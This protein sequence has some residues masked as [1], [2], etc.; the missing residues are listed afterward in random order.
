MRLRSER[1][2]PSQDDGVTTRS[3]V[4]ANNVDLQELRVPA[5]AFVMASAGKLV[6]IAVA[7]L[8]AGI[9]CTLP[10]MSNVIHHHYMSVSLPARAARLSTMVHDVIGAFSVR[11]ALDLGL[12][13]LLAQRGQMMD[14]EIAASLE[15][16]LEGMRTLLEAM[17]SLD[18]LS[19]DA[20][21]LYSMTALSAKHLV[22]GQEPY[23]GSLI[24]MN[25]DPSHVNAFLTIA[26]SVRL[27]RAVKKVPKHD[28]KGAEQVWT[29]FATHTADLSRPPAR[30]MAKM[31]H[32]DAEAAEKR[33][34]PL[35]V[36][37][38]ACG[39]G[40]YGQ[41][42]LRAYPHARVTFL[43]S[44]AV[45]EHAKANGEAEVGPEAMKR[46]TFV[47]G[48]VF[49]GDLG[50]PYDVV[51]AS[52]F[53]QG[54][55]SRHGLSRILK[56][57]A[58]F[59]LL[60]LTPLSRAR[61]IADSF[62]YSRCVELTRLLHAALAPGGL[63]IIQGFIPNEGRPSVWEANPFPRLFKLTVLTMSDGGTSYSASDYRGMLG[64]GGP[65]ASVEVRSASPAPSSFV[66][67]RRAA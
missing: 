42:F 48:D 4:D 14:A 20:T 2:P 65:F 46:A 17:V 47:A 44:K 60:V 10:P 57:L 51:V 41:A 6:A 55:P 40:T 64:E 28:E 23:F 15:C 38:V 18:L 29:T 13:E 27:G 3:E 26:D 62:N 45:V 34:A 50:G 63:L 52:Q 5:S 58:A 66:L 16:N 8:A 9:A 21:G 61:A 36:L 33:G 11:A 53:Y 31:A 67:A 56:R 7:V 49:R 35:R 25:T 19:V 59:L 30:A 32:A 22:K 39:S 1:V 37:D 54:A 43:D 12:F 24:Y